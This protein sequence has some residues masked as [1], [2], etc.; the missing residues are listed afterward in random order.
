MEKQS[1]KEVAMISVSD[2]KRLYSSSIVE[3][4]SSSLVKLDKSFEGDSS[5]KSKSLISSKTASNMNLSAGSLT[6]NSS[7]SKTFVVKDYSQLM[8]GRKS[9]FDDIKTRK[10]FRELGKSACNSIF[11][12]FNSIIEVS[13]KLT[14][15]EQT[16]FDKLE[17][18]CFEPFN[19]QNKD[20][21]KQLNSLID[22]RRKID[23]EDLGFISENPRND[24]R[25]GGIYSLKFMNHFLSYYPHE[26]MDIKLNKLNIPFA[27]ICIQITFLFK[28]YFGFVYREI[29]GLE[30]SKKEIK[31]FCQ[32]LL[33]DENVSI[34]H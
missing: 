19:P 11:G 25:A 6:S 28:Q 10:S 31:K 3:N 13:N 9:G 23:Y 4:G 27:T 34:L 17:S 5:F 30:I 7:T 26:F 16:A 2:S 21:E 29:A 15:Q 1:E 20:H 18:I 33:D 24:F 12:C 22:P 32:L 14:Q 8:V